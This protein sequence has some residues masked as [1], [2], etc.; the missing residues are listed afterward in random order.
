MILNATRS[1]SG[2]P[3]YDAGVP[4][5][6]PAC[7]YIDLQRDDATRWW[8][9]DPHEL[10]SPTVAGRMAA[11]LIAA[12]GDRK[13]SEL[14]VLDLECGKDFPSPSYPIACDFHGL[15][16]NRWDDTVA[17][18]ADAPELGDKY[19]RVCSH[20]LRVSGCAADD[21]PHRHEGDGILHYASAYVD[22]PWWKYAPAVVVTPY[23]QHPGQDPA[24]VAIS[25]TTLLHVARRC[26]AR[27]DV[28]VYATIT[29]RYEHDDG[30]FMLMD[31]WKACVDRIAAHG[32]N[33]ILWG[34]WQDQAAADANRKFMESGGIAAIEEAGLVKAKGGVA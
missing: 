29:P 12:I 26:A 19:E 5:A 18:L 23:L 15:D 22:H 24:A 6:W 8:F 4:A 33:A 9:K 14:C 1:W 16:W 7:R 10:L 13:G 17:M 28:P 11:N 3:A 27:R 25:H 20:L 30:G 34:R 31:E 32:A 2:Q 21:F